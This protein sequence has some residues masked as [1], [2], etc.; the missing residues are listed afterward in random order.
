MGEGRAR[1]KAFGALK[2]YRVSVSFSRHQAHYENASLTLPPIYLHAVCSSSRI[3]RRSIVSIC[4][5]ANLYI[6]G[7]CKFLAAPAHCEQRKSYTD[8]IYWPGVE[9]IRIPSERAMS[10]RERRC[11][12]GILVDKKV[13]ELKGRTGSGLA[14][15]IKVSAKRSSESRIIARTRIE[16]RGGMSARRDII[17]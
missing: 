14:N 7:Q 11:K 2:I 10:E 5:P 16:T 3:T 13:V 15:C 8:P 4:S 1:T 9:E 17:A 12:E 6:W